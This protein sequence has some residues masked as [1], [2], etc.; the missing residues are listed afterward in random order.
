MTLFASGPSILSVTLLQDNVALEEPV[1]NVTLTI[2]PLSPSDVASNAIFKNELT[3]SIIDTD[4][5]C[6]ASVCACVLSFEVE[7]SISHGV[8]L[9][10]GRLDVWSFNWA[11]HWA[12]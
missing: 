3:L 4:G 12:N 2:V 9:V 5:V 1:E 6:G 11:L 10:I 8:R 7:R